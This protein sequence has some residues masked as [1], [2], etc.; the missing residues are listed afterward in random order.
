L[1]KLLF[2]PDNRSLKIFKIIDLKHPVFNLLGLR[3]IIQQHTEAENELLKKYSRNAKVI[4]EIGVAEGGSALTL[5]S[6]AQ[7]DGELFL[8]DPYKP[9]RIPYI[10]LTKVVAK[11]SV[12]SSNSKC[13]VKWIEMYSYQASKYWSKSIDFLF[14]DGDHSYQGCVKDWQDW[15][16]F[17]KRNG[18]VCFHDAR[19]FEGGW[20]L[21]SWGPVKFVNQYFRIS[22]NYNWIIVKEVDSLVVVQKKN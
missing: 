2:R 17:V 12:N 4:V 15:S 18:Y 9:G 8:I 16:P 7:D 21:Q 5:R 22:K 20:T 13:K 1:N 11:K 14:I 19:I 3:G 10:N 6:V